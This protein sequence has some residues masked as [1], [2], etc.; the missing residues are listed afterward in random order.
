MEPRKLSFLSVNIALL[1]NLIKNLSIN[2]KAVVTHS[3]TLKSVDVRLEQW[4]EQYQNKEYMATLSAPEQQ[5]IFKNAQNFWATHQEL[6]KELEYLEFSKV[7]SFIV[8]AINELEHGYLLIEWLSNEVGKTGEIIIPH[9]TCIRPDTFDKGAYKNQIDSLYS[10]LE[11][12]SYDFYKDDVLKNAECSPMLIPISDHLTVAAC[13]LQ[14]E[15]QRLTTEALP[16]LKIIKLPKEI[17]PEV[18]KAPESLGDM[19]VTFTDKNGVTIS[20]D[21]AYKARMEVIHGENHK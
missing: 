10:E 15:K 3:A 9:L 12:I 6:E 13:W 7:P 14:K 5:V 2:K 20:K 1:V 16:E 8:N 19:P 18:P 17:V 4:R 11:A 21:E